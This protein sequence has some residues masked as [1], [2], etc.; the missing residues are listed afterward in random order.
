VLAD[1]ASVVFNNINLFDQIQSALEE[2][3][4]LYQASR[5][6]SDATTP[7]QVLDV[8]ANYLIAPHVNQAFIA[9]LDRPSWDHPGASVRIT[10][11]WNAGEGIDLQGI[12]LNK[13]QFPAWT[14]LAAKT[15][16]TIDDIYNDPELSEDEQSE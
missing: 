10:A 8:V 11:S 9:L 5:A 3:S 2:T 6:L 1:S 7:Q 13:D 16:R 4:T 15:A 14:L 12:T